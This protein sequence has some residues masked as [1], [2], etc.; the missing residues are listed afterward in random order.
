MQTSP[1]S[2]RPAWQRFTKLC[3]SAASGT[4]YFQK[5]LLAKAIRYKYKQ[6]REN[7]AELL[8]FASGGNAAQ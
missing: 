2:V 3:F 5:V 6:P 8:Q 4:G 7:D 1:Y